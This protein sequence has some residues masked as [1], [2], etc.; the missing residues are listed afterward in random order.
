M[1]VNYFVNDNMPSNQALQELYH[2][3]GWD[4]YVTNHKNM[5]RLLMNAAC[6]VVAYDGDQLVGLC[7]AISDGVII[8]YIQDIW[9]CPEFQHQ[10]VGTQL[11]QQLSKEL[12]HIR[13]IVLI[14]D[15]EPK[16]LRF[17]QKNQLN[18]LQ[19]FDCTGFMEINQ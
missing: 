5:Q 3:V 6:F 15:T 14:T 12:D 8:A 11:L 19:E 7:R 18:I 17:Y 13:Q 4:I 10:G 2:S 9:V 16:T 1:A